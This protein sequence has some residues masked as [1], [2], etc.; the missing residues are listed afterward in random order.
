MVTEERVPVVRVVTGKVADLAPAPTTT[1][2]GTV[3]SVVLELVRATVAPPVGAGPFN[4]TVAVGVWPRGTLGRSSAVENAWIEGVT[5][6]VAVF[7][8]PPDVAV[9]V[10]FVFVATVNVVTMK[11]VDAAP[12]GTVTL[13]GTVAAAVFE[14]VSATMVPPGAPKPFI[15]I[16]AVE[17]EEPKA[18]DGARATESG[19]GTAEVVSVAV[20]LRPTFAAVIVVEPVVVAGSVGI[21]NVAKV[22][23]AGIVMLAGTVARASTELVRVTTA[24]PAG[25]GASSVTVPVALIP[26]TT[27]AGLTEREVRFAPSAAGDAS[28]SEARTHAFGRISNLPDFSARGGAVSFSARTEPS[29]HRVASL[30]PL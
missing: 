17:V 7:E 21:A 24:P 15:A 1:L 26:P 16:V 29:F 9:I 27:L 20:R 28:R 18:V 22:A 2:A 3:A 13:A 23:P 14:L 4:V 25:A 8:V 10:T 6:C 19:I 11:V 5:V 12:A 30:D